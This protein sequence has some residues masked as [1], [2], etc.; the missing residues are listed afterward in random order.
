MR[1]TIII[2]ICVSIVGYIGYHEI[3]TH[4]LKN[5]FIYISNKVKE[6]KPEQGTE[7]MVKYLKNKAKKDA[8]LTDKN[9]LKLALKYIKNN[10]ENAKSIKVQENLI[11]YGALLQYSPKTSDEGSVTLIGIKT[12]DAV[13]DVYIKDNSY[14]KRKT[15]INKTKAQIIKALISRV[16][17]N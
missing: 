3:K 14:K 6:K 17:I 5:S 12:I 2:L 9:T 15:K 1:K 10:I 11:Y 13:S 7:E 16:D 4:D 8:D